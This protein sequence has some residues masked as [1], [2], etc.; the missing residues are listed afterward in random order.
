MLPVPP[1]KPPVPTV[2]A[3]SLCSAA[4]P[5]A[6]RQIVRRA[7]GDHAAMSRAVGVACASVAALRSG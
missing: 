7:K 2:R 4:R 5:A 1:N 6:Q 3:A